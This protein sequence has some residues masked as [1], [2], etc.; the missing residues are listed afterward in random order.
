MSLT[1]CLK[2]GASTLRCYFSSR[3]EL[4]FSGESCIT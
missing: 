2:A 1:L 3:T 4:I